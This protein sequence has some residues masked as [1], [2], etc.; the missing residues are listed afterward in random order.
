M[1]SPM[2]L[3]TELDRRREPEARRGRVLIVANRLP[4]TAQVADGGVQLSP[5]SGGLAT[6]LRGVHDR[7][8]GLWIGW[9][10]TSLPP[11]APERRALDRRLAEIGA[12]P[13]DMSE[14]EVRR[15]YAGYSNAV[16][17]PLL[18]DRVDRMATPDEWAAYQRINER[19]ADVV[20]REVRPGDTIW[21]HDYHLMLVPALL[22]ERCPDARIGFFLHTPFPSPDVLAALPERA[23]LLD[24]LLGA[25]LV[26]FHTPQYVAH[27]LDAVG[28]VLGHR[29]DGEVVSSGGRRVRVRDFPM[30]IDAAAFA[31]RAEDARVARDVAELRRDGEALFVG[32]DRLDYTKGIPERL[33]AFARFLELEPSALGRVRLRQLAVP[34]REDVPAYRTLRAEVERWVARINARFARPGWRPI[35]YTYGSVDGSRLSALYRAADVMLVTPLRDGMNLVA[36]EFVASRTDHDGV[37]VL[38]IGAGAAAALREA[39]LVDPRDVDGLAGAYRAALAMSPGERRVRMRRLRATVQ[40]SDVFRWTS[41]F[42][43][44]LGA[45]T[46]SLAF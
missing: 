14:E 22:R 36:K 13:V 19:Y 39:L 44:S 4:V 45:P 8:G 1:S 34:S 9:S 17:W 10:G 6:G 29:V 11:A 33:A 43:E 24:G 20:A 35:E 32:V 18:H 25:D 46:A 31:A 28:S 12:V 42:L 30:G 37:L 2:F 26:G 41:D 40:G 15:F 16:L 27:F 5:S 7:S 3:P 23:T 21:V 38:G